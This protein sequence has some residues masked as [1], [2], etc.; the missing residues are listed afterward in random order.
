MSRAARCL[1]PYAGSVL[2]YLPVV[3]VLALVVYCLIE[4][5]QTPSEEVRNLPK[6]A[7]IAMI[8][9]LDVIGC[10][11]WLFA[12][13]PKRQPAGAG[14]AQPQQGLLG[15]FSGH[16]R[17]HAVAPDDDPEF[18][19]RLKKSNTEH[20]RILDQWEREMRRKDAASGGDPAKP[21]SPAPEDEAGDPDSSRS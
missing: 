17:R 3:L 4:C 15:G 12:G 11:A 10:L 6:W 1:P 13:R 21:A 8:V 2:R 19:D 7:W 5:I 16:P 18:L 14:G 9:L 20:D